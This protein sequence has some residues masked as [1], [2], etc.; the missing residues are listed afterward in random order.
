MGT[1][2]SYQEFLSRVSTH[3]LCFLFFDVAQLPYANETLALWVPRPVTIGW[4]PDWVPRVGTYSFFYFLFF[5]WCSPTAI[6]KWGFCLV[7]TQTSYQGLVSRVGTYFLLFLFSN[8][9]LLQYANGILALWVPR[10]ITKGFYPEWV[11]IFFILSFFDAALLRHANET[12]ALWVPRPV[13][14]GWYPH[15]VHRVGTLSGYSFSLV[16]LFS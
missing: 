2:T 5:I 16:F 11:L 6:C 7:G 1:Q 12:L 15:W 10:P 3:F 9:A 8:A 4:Y 14:K 13:T